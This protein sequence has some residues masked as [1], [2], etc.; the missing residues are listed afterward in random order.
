MSAAQQGMPDSRR[1]RLRGNWMPIVL[2]LV[3]VFFV[4]IVG[5]F[6][7][8]YLR[9]SAF[10]E[11]RA[12][13]VLG[14]VSKQFDNM[15]ETLGSLLTLVPESLLTGE[16]GLA[17]TG[18]YIAKLKL[19]DLNLKRFAAKTPTA[20]DRF[21]VVMD[22]PRRPFTVH[23]RAATRS[24]CSLQITGTLQQHLP[25]F[26]AQRYFDEVLLTLQSGAVLGTVSNRS[27][28]PARA[29]LHPDT[30]IDRP[31]ADARLLLLRAAAE[32]DAGRLSDFW[33]TQAE[34]REP[35]YQQPFHS[36]AFRQSIGGH[37]YVVSVLPIIPSYAVRVDT[38]PNG[39]DAQE[40]QALLYL[41]GLKR[42]H[43]G[44]QATDALGPAGTLTVTTLVLLGILLWPF[45]GLRLATKHSAI[46]GFQ[47][48]AVI[49]SLLLIPVVLT[50]CGVWLW[51]DLRLLVWADRGAEHYAAGIERSLRHELEESVLLLDAYRDL[52]NSPTA[53]TSAT[54]APVRLDPQTRKTALATIVRQPGGA[55]CK[56]FLQSRPTPDDALG[57]WSPIRTAVP[58]DSVGT[59]IA[60]R[61]TAFGN[62]PVKSKLDVRDRAYFRSLS[63]GQQWMSSDDH[64]EPVPFVAQRLF[65]RSD[66]ARTLQLAIPRTRE[67]LWRGAMIG[68][69]RV[70]GLT[71]G[72]RPPLLRF[73]VIDR[74]NGEVLFHS[75]DERS[76]A[77]NL[78]T[79]TDDNAALRQ[80]LS[81]GGWAERR[82]ALEDHFSTQYVGEPHRFYY[83]S[84]AGVPWGVVVYYPTRTLSEISL[85]ATIATL[86]TCIGFV[87][88]IA[89]M[90]VAT[91][92]FGS[93]RPD[94]HLLSCIWPQWEWRH[95]Y[96][97]IA[98][99]LT[100]FGAI[101]IAGLIY[102]LRY[103]HA[104]IV[105][106]VVIATGILIAL[107]FARFDAIAPRT[108]TPRAYRAFYA[109]A[110]V[111]FIA[112]I[113]I[114]PT[115]MLAFRYQDVSMQGYLRNALA[116]SANDVQQRRR[117][118][119][120]DL[121][122]WVPDAAER[123]ARYPDGWT[124]ARLLPVPG[125]RNEPGAE[126]TCSLWSMTAFPDLPWI[127]A[128]GP[129]RLDMIR[130]TIWRVTTATSP[131]E[132]RGVR[133]TAGGGDSQPRCSF[134][135]SSS[136]RDAV[137]NRPAVQRLLRTEDDRIIR[138]RFEATAAAATPAP[139]DDVIHRDRWWSTW[140]A[141]LLSLALLFVLVVLV[142][143]AARR[144]F[145]IY[146]PFGAR[147]V[148][149]APQAG[150]PFDELLETEL[151]IDQ[152]KV[153]LGDRFTDKD[154]ADLRRIHCTGRYQQLWSTLSADERHLLHQLA[155]GQFANPE[156]TA[157]IESLLYKRYIRLR[158]WPVINDQGFADFAR[159]APE[160]EQF[161]ADRRQ[162]AREEAESTWNR[163]RKPLLLIG[164][165]LAIGLMALAGTTMQIVSTAL[166]AITA[167]LGSVTQVTNF[168][169]KD[170]GS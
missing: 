116:Q 30:S 24:G 64:G 144:L 120:S 89:L 118:M 17:D 19:T 87:T 37:T 110:V 99:G 123:Q 100:C 16:C 80:A 90:L 161:S 73:A 165:L 140:N 76:L 26:V 111:A 139:N 155:M 8:Q 61:I 53:C 88:L 170:G 34:K 15:Q 44:Q 56:I 133:S 141:A 75:D 164:V 28:D 83:R 121:A 146:L 159:S 40:A 50:A 96:P 63:A 137:A 129:A 125:F 59:S 91:A 62:V 92:F 38:R 136:P 47:V 108:T 152:L 4:G 134:A 67:T 51:N 33:N 7:L 151:K 82:I 10:Q 119:Q 167:L 143:N 27:G 54:D 150:F 93:I 113:V 130:R 32:S 14:E 11:E 166:A 23:T 162:W 104:W 95:S 66:A 1:I 49:V 74:A 12:F 127:D 126:P 128:D 6:A 45:I 18:E 135:V 39:G 81:S 71:A 20:G 132:R 57:N 70:Y 43:L 157:T 3:G 169:R 117:L 94:R 55:D 160:L 46:S 58:L 97:R 65:N 107:L 142:A 60:P 31:V 9:G 5:Y 122:R 52:A 154:A 25:A 35:L 48:F 147:H 114:A 69:T 101:L 138:I 148:E 145:G 153:Q 86:A 106:L 103:G 77:E 102:C 163:V 84:M 79:E 36:V 41:I 29:D 105:G 22:D 72:I 2:T 112:V 156:N 109:W 131:Q 21:D 149:L 13:R 42:Q 158:P 168:V 85:D 124:L 78:L 98:L 68:D 115:A